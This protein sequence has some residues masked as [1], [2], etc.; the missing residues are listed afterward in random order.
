MVICVSLFSQVKTLQ[1]IKVVEPPIIDGNLDDAAWKNITAA[2]NFIQNFPHVG[3]PALQRTEVKMVYDDA[4]IY[5]AAYLYDDPT[6]IRKQMNARDEEQMKDLDYFS[7]FLDT[8]DDDQNGFQFL[9]TSSNVQTDARLSP[10]MEASFNQYGD[11]TWDAVWDSKV[12]IKDS[13]W[14]VE[15][16]IPFF[17][18]RFAKKNIQDWGVQFM[19]SVRRNNETS[20]WNNVDPQVDGFVNQFGAFKG[21]VNITPPLRLSFSPYVSTGIRSTPTAD[22]HRNEWLKSGGMDVK[23]GIDE[24]FTL[25]ATLIPDFG[26]VVSDNVVNNLTPYEVQF[27]DYRP[28]FTEGTEIFNKAGLFYSRRIGA[29]PSGYQAVRELELTDPNIEV[30]KNPGRTQLYNALKLSGRTK[31]KLGVGFFNAV[32][33]P[34][35]ATIRDKTSGN[36]TKI[37]TEP[38]ANYNIIVLDQALKGRSYITF[39]NTNVIRN[40]SS[41]D[42][43]VT[44]INFSV[45]DKTNTF[46]VRGA[47]GYSRVFA[48]DPYEGFN[49]SLRAGKV[50]GKIQYNIQNV[51]RSHRYDPTDLGYLQTANQVINT[52]EAS[53]NQFKPTSKFLS[54]NYLLTVIQRQ[55]YR[56]GKFND[57]TL[58]AKGFWMFK[59]FWDVT[60]TTAYLPDQ[61]DYYIIGGDFSKYAR[62]PQYGFVELEGSTDSRKKLFIYYDFL[63]ANFFKNPE[64]EYYRIS[65]GGR[66][67]FSNK[68]SL[69]LSHRHET[70]T[71]YIISAGR[72]VMNE[73][74]MAFVDFRE[75][76][77]IFSGI[78]NFTPRINLT[79]RLRHYWSN[80]LVKRTAYIDDKGKPVSPIPAAG[81]DDN[82]NYFNVDAFFTWDFRYGSRLILGYKNWLGED[83]VV[84]GSRHRHYV[85]N[86][87]K[88]FGLRHGNELTARFIY[89]LDYSQLKRKK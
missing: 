85:P 68:F 50:S 1:A 49:A 54:Y 16:K 60:L 36:R 33:A 5:V 51:T 22:G 64:K 67:R 12:S 62:R 2:T 89:F 19:R 9:V 72:D 46:N 35:Y 27:N 34:M 26:Q 63:V 18:L 86:L 7:L 41:R 3:Q 40:G 81:L 44:G 55:L 4:A 25:D 82:I 83:Q 65:G 56:P 31:K 45:Y 58:G 6:L 29:A 37:Q 32:A 39:T 28:F 38:L 15:M 10:S 59:N 8:Y 42:A 30:V 84:D 57:L 80:V 77:S 11:K 71:D 61:H 48:A 53:Y 23:Y 52:A 43:N 47:G 76:E 14:V 73:P 66:F 21:L 78:Y 79:M 70:E 20:F 13:G 75:A 69:D 24:S 87:G 74:K 17:S 88:T